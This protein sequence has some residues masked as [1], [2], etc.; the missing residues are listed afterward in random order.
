MAASQPDRDAF[1]IERLRD[2]GTI[3]LAKLNLADWYGKASGSGSTLGGMVIS[4]Y[5]IAKYPGA[6]SSGSGV[7]A[8]AWFAT[9]ALGSDTGG[10]LLIPSALNA[11]VA[12]S[13][14]R[15]LVSRRGMMWNSPAQEKGGPMARSV[16]DAAA[17][18]DVIAG[19][20]TGD[21][22]TVASFGNMPDKRYTSFVKKDGLRGAR[23]G[24]LREM[25]RSGRRTKR[26]GAVRARAGGA[27]EGRG[28]RDRSRAHGHRPAGRAVRGK[29]RRL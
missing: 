22:S 25:V 29:Q 11:V 26:A 14:T 10:S 18:L 5:N 9:V 7:A 12:I 4:P 3:I 2:A 19:Y 20:D 15:G 1:V 17:V 6:S 23:V 21:L 28:D 16:Y 13:P 27:T 8:A 24:V